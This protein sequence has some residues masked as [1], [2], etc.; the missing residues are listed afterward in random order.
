MVVR[1]SL[2]TDESKLNFTLSPGLNVKQ[3]FAELGDFD[4]DRYSIHIS[5]FDYEQVASLESLNLKALLES[6]CSKFDNFELKI[7]GFV[8]IEAANGKIFQAATFESQ[9]LI[10]LRKT[11]DE[12]FIEIGASPVVK[13]IEFLMPLSHHQDLND[14]DTASFRR[15]EF[16]AIEVEMRRGIEILTTQ[17]LESSSIDPEPFYIAE[18]TD[19]C[20]RFAIVET[21]TQKVVSCHDS[22]SEAKDELDRLLNAIG[23]KADEILIRKYDD[24]TEEVFAKTLDDIDTTPTEAMRKQAEIG[25]RMREEYGR[26]GTSVGVA[27]ARDIQNGRSLSESTIKRMKSFFARHA[28]NKKAKG[29]NPGEEG[30]PS[31]GK[32][33]WLLW[34]SD[35]GETWAN[36]KVEEFKRVRDQMALDAM[37]A[38]EFMITG[39]HETSM[40]ALVPANPEKYALEDGLEMS[41]LHITLRYLGETEDLDQDHLDEAIGDLER[42]AKTTSEFEVSDWEIAYFGNKEVRDSGKVAV[43]AH[44]SHDDETYNL[45]RIHQEV[46][47]I[48]DS[49]DLENKSS[50]KD[51][52]WQAHMTLGYFD[53]AEAEERFPEGAS[54]MPGESI[55]FSGLRIANGE[56]SVIFDFQEP[57]DDSEKITLDAVEYSELSLEELDP[58]AELEE[59]LEKLQQSPELKDAF[60]QILQDENQGFDVLEDEN[61]EA[62]VSDESEV[63]DFASMSADEILAYGAK[64]HMDSV[65][66][67][68]IEFQGVA[69]IE[70]MSTGDNRYISVGALGNR[71]LPLPFMYGDEKTEGHLGARLG[72]L[73]TEIE[74][75]EKENKRFVIV[76][77]HFRNHPFGMEVREAFECGD[78]RGVSVDLSD[79]SVIE[80]FVDDRPRLNVTAAKIM[81]M[82]GTPF[83]A[84]ENASVQVVSQAS[85]E[86][87]LVASGIEGY[88]PEM[89]FWLNFDQITISE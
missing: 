9:D 47:E 46:S 29:W 52:P 43:V 57:E 61:Q 17:A 50:F 5:A 7:S 19:E 41:D 30:Y 16:R 45:N 13:N 23:E 39:V 53:L 88:K 18:D 68:P 55:R 2:F 31:A 86:N 49:Y 66:L 64:S 44:W 8:P 81:G 67:K 51:E 12:K 69:V 76:R 37:D 20:P 77:G 24:M 72:G 80:E 40:V 22:L 11:I 65:A 32:I 89:S 27:R 10:A 34:G 21:E 75:I 74:Y 14:L 26:G 79:L 82:T 33:A 83:P 15:L 84:F 85:P 1:M 25:L 48:L 6:A 60:R 4:V 58:M 62:P 71:E 59:I 28:V 78:M 56:D 42:W 63:V 87:A 35:P 54:Y 38:G 36:A 3:A 73:I 70:G